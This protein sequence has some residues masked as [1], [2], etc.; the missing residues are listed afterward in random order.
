M[1]PTTAP[2]SAFKL[3]VLFF[4]ATVQILSAE[5]AQIVVSADGR[6]NFRTVQEALNSIPKDNNHS[7]MI[8]IKKGIYPEKIFIERSFVALVGEDRDSTTIIYAELREEWT[9]NHNGSD[10]GSAVIN[11]DSASTDVT[12]ANLTINN[13]YGSLHQIPKHQF[14]IR[15]N[16]TRIRILY[17]NVIADGNDTVSLWNRTN[18]M[19]Y[20]A[21]CSFEGW[22]DYVCPRGW[23]YITDSKFF[24]HNMS[25]SIWHDGSANKEQKFVIRYSS[26]DGVPGFPLGRHHRDA[27]I[28]LLDCLFSRAMADKPIYLPDSPNS[29][30]WQWGERHYYYNCHREGGDFEWF[31]DNLSQ[32]EKAP[33]PNDVTAQWAFDGAWDPEGTM[34]SVLPF[35]SFPTPRNC[36]Y[37][38][39]RDNMVLRWVPS[40]NAD[41]SLIS[42]AKGDTPEFRER[43]QANTFAVGQLEPNTRYSWRIDEV[44]GVDTLRGP[45][46]HFTTQR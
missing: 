14:A 19:Y 24:G 38:V 27:Q 43:R 6:G 44:S 37:G 8:L 20:H 1:S 4:L 30:P 12:V 34:P 46:W 11:I 25:A 15:G 39:S 42:F 33:K 13:N 40:R 28:Y 17:C 21:Y 26:F 9:K 5:R 31:A 32:A 29:R 35:V 45:V 23:C 3:A 16:G 36:F 41:G 10:W 2:Q 22:V 7:V 18:G